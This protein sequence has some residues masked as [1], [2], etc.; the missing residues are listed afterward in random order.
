MKSER[1]FRGIPASPGIV[2]GSAYVVPREKVYIEVGHLLPEE[3]SGE[4]D[5]LDRAVDKAKR[6]LWGMKKEIVAKEQRAQARR[7]IDA[8]LG[9]LED[10]EFIG[11]VREKVKDERKR[12]SKA[13]YEVASCLIDRFS[14]ME[15]DYWGATAQEVRALAMMILRNLAPERYQ[16]LEGFPIGRRFIVVAHDLPLQET[17]RLKKERVLGLVTEVGGKTSHISILAKSMGV[18]AVVGIEGITREVR[19]GDYL[20]L[21]GI[22]G[23]VI[24][25]PGEATLR[26]YE[27]KRKQFESMEKELAEFCDLPAVT[28]DGYSVDLSANIELPDEVDAVLEHR[29][30]GIG[31]FRTEF[32]FLTGMGFPDE[33]E[34]VEIYTTVAEKIY[35]HS[36]IIRTIDIGGDKFYPYGEQEKN[37]FLG[38]RAIRFCLHNPEVLMIQLR[39]ILRA[40]KKGNLKVMFPMVSAV[41]EIKQ[42]RDIISEVKKELRQKKVQFNPHIDIGMMVE[43]PSAAL[44]ADKFAKYVH[45]FSIGSNDLTQYTLAVDRTNPRVSELYDHLDPSVLSLIKRTVE[46]GH[47][48]NIWV[49]VC[50][51]VAADPLG[52][53]VLLGFGVDEL[54]IVPSA[55]PEVKKI[56]R[57]F[58]MTEAVKIA[59]RALEFSTAGE[60]R[61]YL[62]GEITKRFPGLRF[63]GMEEV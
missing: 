47:S 33:E 18:P 60:V 11:K 25:N 36:V 58:S 28:L 15:N 34:Q 35:P 6:E 7:I 10:P 40:N 42:L 3:I 24:V 44:L 63:I 55:L 4:L 1:V 39:A 9:M 23:V 61:N 41:E 48:H 49:G 14:K 59:K 21:D 56:I 5:R 57:G 62:R 20:I 22:R 27:E 19:E 54:S 51:E 16:S 13:V 29:A 50:G 43:V 52:V 12:A 26:E 38:W 2:A 46:A 37:P 53:P 45:F 32:L 30:R 17:F 8:H 31:L